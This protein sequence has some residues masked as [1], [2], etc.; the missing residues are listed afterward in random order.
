MT[1]FTENAISV[2]SHTVLS[3]SGPRTVD[4]V[5]YS[6]HPLDR[7]AV[8][9]VAGHGGMVGSAMVRRL[10]WGGFRRI[11]TRAHRM[12]DLRD[13]DAVFEFFAATRPRYVVLAAAKVGGIAAND[14]DPAGFL[15][16][17]VQIQVNVM[18]AAL[19]YDTERLLFLGSSCIYPRL[20]PQPI[21]ENQLLGGYLEPTN[22]AYAIAKIAGIV[23]VQSVRRQYGR[24]WICAMPTN[25][26]GPGDNFSVRGSHVLPALIRRYDEAAR[27]GV[28][29]VT[30]WGT[31]AARREFLHVD[32]LADAC[33]HLLEHYDGPLQVNVGTG[34][35][36]TIRDLA[37]KVAGAV[38]YTGATLWDHSKPDG[39]PQKLLSVDRLSATGWAAAIGLDEGI[40]Q[41]VDW[42]RRHRTE[43]RG[44]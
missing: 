26:Y 7:D 38:G 18:D 16:D 27:L 10:E 5:R 25:L 39:T 35:D 44:A 36:L 11:L 4:D 6:P 28:P 12:L 32:E 9:Y 19:R 43:V 30:N 1:A 3:E 14:A 15:S 2:A 20:A 42:Y 8:I 24:P 33:L 23:H 37:A 13:R 22:D 17:N 34:T 31:G 29:A 41:T 21:T 40:R